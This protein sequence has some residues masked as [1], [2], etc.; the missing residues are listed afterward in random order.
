M[1]EPCFRGNI[2]DRG[3]AKK[4]KKKM[5]RQYSVNNLCA[6]YKFKLNS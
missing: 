2:I 4:V 6:D 3:I 5:L 1:S